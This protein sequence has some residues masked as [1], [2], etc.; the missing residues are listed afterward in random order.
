MLSKETG[1]LFVVISLIYMGLTNKKRFWTL[2]WLSALLLA[3]YLPLKIHAVG[4]AFEAHNAP[5]QEISLL[6]RIINI[7]EMLMFYITR[8]VF[9]L[10]LAQAYYWQEG[11]ITFRHF[12]L[13]LAFDFVV[14]LAMFVIGKK[15]VGKDKRLF[16]VYL[17]F[18]VWLLAGLAMHMQ[19]VPLDMTVSESWFYFSSIGALGMLGA[20]SIV[21]L[22]KK[23]YHMATVIVVA[24]LLLFGVRTFIRGY[25]WRD[26]TTLSYKNISVSHEDYVSY[27][28]IANNSLRQGN[29]REAERYASTSVKIYPFG[30]NYNTL[31]AAEFQL[32]KLGEARDAYEKA[33]KYGGDSEMVYQ[34]L[35]LLYAMY[36]D[37]SQAKSFYSM[38]VAKFPND[39][40]IWFYAA[41][42]AN[43]HGYK[44][45]AIQAINTARTLGYYD[46]DAFQKITAGQPYSVTLDKVK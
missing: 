25:D 4:V 6:Q 5:I 24:I 17:F 27:N 29:Y 23:Y 22:P 9:P 21:L 10:G 18:G 26:Q 42:F 44:N 39:A 13:P 40:Q 36:D 33:I 38:A 41:V 14:I 43:N 16:M 1:I 12:F 2:V 8:F 34:N 45:T 20:A 19:V 28:L 46:A 7:P 30:T 31:A 11:T 37:S 32:G 15:I 35:A 3:V